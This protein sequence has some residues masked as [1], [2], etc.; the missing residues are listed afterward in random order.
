MPC[1]C[2]TQKF[3][4][5]ELSHLTHLFL[6]SHSDSTMPT[7][8]ADFELNVFNYSMPKWENDIILYSVQSIRTLFCDHIG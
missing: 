1:N 6:T 5:L 2:L 3:L 8:H 4:L 7:L